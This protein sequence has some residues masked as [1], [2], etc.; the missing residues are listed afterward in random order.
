RAVREAFVAA[1]ESRG[2][3]VLAAPPGTGKSTQA[4]KF[5]L[6][7]PG[8]IWVLQPRRVAA[9]SLAQRVARELNEPLGQTV[10]YQVRFEA[11]T[12][13][14][15]RIHFLTY[16]IFRQRMLRQPTLP[17]VGTV[18]LDEFHERSLEADLA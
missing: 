11:Q 8:Q 12:G 3:V 9:R 17:G 5:C 16:G 13:S 18:L 15:T 6:E 10:G 4:P 1:L 2:Q 7:R 14:D